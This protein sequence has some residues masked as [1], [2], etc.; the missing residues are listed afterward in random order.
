MQCEG[1]LGRPRRH[2][3]SQSFDVEILDVIDGH[4]RARRPAILFR[5]SGP[6]RVDA[7]GIG[8]GFSR[9]AD[10]CR[11]GRATPHAGARWASADYEQRRAL[12]TPIE[13]CSRSPGPS[14]PPRAPAP[15]DGARAQRRAVGGRYRRRRSRSAPQA[16]LARPHARPPA[17]PSRPPPQVAGRRHADRPPA[18]LRGRRGRLDGRTRP[19][20]GSSPT[21]ARSDPPGFGHPLDGVGKRSLF[22]Q[23][24]FVHRVIGN[25]LGPTSP[26]CH[27]NGLVR[28]T[29][30]GR[31]TS[32]GPA[33][34]GT[35]GGTAGDRRGSRSR[36]RR[37]TVDRDGA[38]TL[39][40]CRRAPARL[41]PAALALLS[42]DRGRSTA[43][44]GDRLDFS[45]ARSYGTALHADRDP[46]A[47]SA[48]GLLQPRTSATAVLG[49]RD[50]DGRRASTSHRR[51]YRAFDRRQ[52]TV[53]RVRASLD[54]EDALRAH[55]RPRRGRR[56]RARI[57]VRSHQRPRGRSS[58]HV[59][60]RVR[61]S[62]IRA[63]R[64]ARPG[65]APDPGDAFSLEAIFRELVAEHR[66]S[67]VRP[68]KVRASRRTSERSPRGRDIHRLRRIRAHVPPR[69]A[70][71]VL[72]RLAR[73]VGGTRPGA[74]GRSTRHDEARIGGKA[75]L[76]SRPFAAAGGRDL[77]D[78]GRA[79]CRRRRR[80]A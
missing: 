49:D 73:R 35:L 56:R 4:A 80:A 45:A 21:A 77:L 43:P 74:A 12:A 50:R 27:V 69:A 15:T 59:Q 53:D 62:W 47:R 71:A 68:A 44:I 16:L 72:H 24:A 5:V 2:A 70:R 29:S 9:L 26:P 39:Q 30:P 61:G 22:L 46:G 7:T 75:K 25:P 37:A 13:R 19:P 57:R 17:D 36:A 1:P 54:A 51:A 52:S 23:G 14:P 32:T 8:P 58:R 40:C 38:P 31:S 34:S 41:P 55:G 66:G 76:P 64:H 6:R 11:R 78:R 42:V 10:H 79:G 28:R 20:S 3:R 18:R 63:D 65:A 33:I 48:D 60:V 67:S